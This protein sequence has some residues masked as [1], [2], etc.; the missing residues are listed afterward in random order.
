MYKREFIRPPILSHFCLLRLFR[1][2][3]D[4]ETPRK[5]RKL[6]ASS[7]NASN[8][9]WTAFERDVEEFIIQ[10]VSGKG[11]LAFGFV[12]GPLVQALREGNWYV[13][14]NIFLLHVLN[15]SG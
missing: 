11:R 12:E 13:I 6:D 3:L 7:L 5:R 1:E 2:D 8:D 10:Y 4:S 15:I 14:Q 9:K